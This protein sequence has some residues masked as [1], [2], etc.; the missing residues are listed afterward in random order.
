HA[1][2]GGA[3]LEA[4]VESIRHVTNRNRFGHVANIVLCAAHVNETSSKFRDLKPR[5]S[6]FPP[7][8]TSLESACAER[9]RR[10]GGRGFLPGLTV[11]PRSRVLLLG[12][13]GVPAER[14]GTRFPSQPAQPGRRSTPMRQCRS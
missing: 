7:F 9:G 12:I 1:R 8:P 6:S 13:Q 11:N 4:P 5:A 14:A 3:S 2:L 10:D